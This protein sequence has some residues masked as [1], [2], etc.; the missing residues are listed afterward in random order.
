MPGLVVLGPP[1][2]LDTKGAASPPPRLPAEPAGDMPPRVG[3]PPN[4][5]REPPAKGE[6]PATPCG[7]AAA[8]APAPAPA[9]AAVAAAAAAAPCSHAMTTLAEALRNAPARVVSAKAQT[10]EQ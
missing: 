4:G 2:M 10:A 9:V 3:L 6:P 1:G 5:E 8:I 7:D